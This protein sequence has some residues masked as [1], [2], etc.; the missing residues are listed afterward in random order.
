MARCVQCNKRRV[1]VLDDLCKECLAEFFAGATCSRCDIDLGPDG[2][3]P[4]DR[5][6]ERIE[7]MIEE[8]KLLNPGYEPTGGWF[9]DSK[10]ESIYWIMDAMTDHYQ[11]RT[12]FEPWVVG[13][14]GRELLGSTAMGRYGLAHQFQSGLAEIPVDFPPV[15]WWLFLYPEGLNWSS[16]DE[17]DAHAVIA[18]VGRE[19]TYADNGCNMLRVGCLTQRVGREVEWAGVARMGRIEAARHLNQITVNL[20]DAHCR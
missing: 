5:C 18:H 19:R 16:L 17:K 6:D 11:V 20:L 2:L 4:N 3:C 8:T 10:R 1:L 7:E 15:D 9:P 14:V 13:L 12:Q